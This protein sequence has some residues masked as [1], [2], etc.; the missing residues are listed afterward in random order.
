MIIKYCLTVTE[1]LKVI[2]QV[3]VFTSDTKIKQSITSV[4]LQKKKGEKRERE[5]EREE[6]H[7][8]H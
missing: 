7:I 8:L 5:R 3:L 2:V 1:L 4:Q 6:R